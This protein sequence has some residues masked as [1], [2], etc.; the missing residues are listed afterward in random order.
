MYSKRRRVWSLVMVRNQLPAQL[1]NT[2]LCVRVFPSFGTILWK[3]EEVG[4]REKR[5]RKRERDFSH[6]A[7]PASRSRLIN[8]QPSVSY[9]PKLNAKIERRRIER[10]RKG[11][12]SMAPSGAGPRN[13]L[14][15]KF[16]IV[17]VW[18]LA[19]ITFPYAVPLERVWFYDPRRDSWI[20][21]RFETRVEPLDASNKYFK[22]EFR[23]IRVLRTLLRCF[24]LVHTR[25]V[26]YLIRRISTLSA[27]L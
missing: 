17:D 14:G 3:T 13:P 22:D 16:S 27:F 8:R 23:L 26:L 19:K 1:V 7:P 25:I 20:S 11:R 18:R 10:W 2:R 6:D 21:Q 12:K 5:K 4:R 24:V 9:L 15:K